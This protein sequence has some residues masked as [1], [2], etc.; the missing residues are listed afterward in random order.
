MIKLS[1]VIPSYKD[2]K[3]HKTIDDLLENSELGDQ[4]EIIPVLDGYWPPAPI[5]Q[6]DRVRVLHLGTNVG[7]RSAINAGVRISRGEYI[8]RVDE[9]CAFEKG[10]DKEMV[11]TCPDNGIIT[12]VR[13]YLDVD[14]WTRMDKPPVIYEKLVIQSIEDQKK[15][16]GFPWKER[17]EERKDIPIDETMAMQGSVWVMPRK[18]WDT[19]GELDNKYG[20]HYQD[21][22]EM[23]FKTWKKGGKMMINKN[24]WYAH[25]HNKF[26][27]TH[28]L[29]HAKLKNYYPVFMQ[30]WRD[31][32]Q[33][34]KKKWKI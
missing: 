1:V 14:K 23:I 33:E 30:D 28:R 32:Y 15:F 8:M 17:D 12:G 24:K 20:S 26:P 10:F 29:T 7:M 3:L 2:P 34:I 13:Y 6:D 11:E 21:Q 16:C 9:H 5:V 18:W 19:I 4:L 25:R 22:H 27:R 31:Y